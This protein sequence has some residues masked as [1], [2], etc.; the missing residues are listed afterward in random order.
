MRCMQAWQ[1]HQ[2]WQ[3]T[4]HSGSAIMH[5]FHAC[6]SGSTPGLD[7]RVLSSMHNETLARLL[8]M[9]SLTLPLNVFFSIVLDSRRALLM[10]SWLC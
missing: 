1:S 9:H 6:D 3:Y 10:C 5:T 2:L 4:C 8:G 7:M